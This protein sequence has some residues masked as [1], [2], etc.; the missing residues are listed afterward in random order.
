MR[1][2]TVY[3]TVNL[4][5]GREYT[6][7]HET[8]DLDDGYLGSGNLIKRAIEKHG[9]ENFRKVLLHDFDSAGE[10]DARG[11]IR[12]AASRAALPSSAGEPERGTARPVPCQGYFRSRA[13]AQ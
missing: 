2:N 3:R 6:G 5:N 11:S 8:D 7:K 13:G 12:N 1:H 9:R 4:V 10:M